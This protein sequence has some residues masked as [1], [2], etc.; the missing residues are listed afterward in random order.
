MKVKA[1]NSDTKD[2][3]MKDPNRKGWIGVDLDG[4]LARYESGQYP[5]IGEPL[6]PMADYVRA[7]IEEDQFEVKIFTA[8]ACEPEQIP[9]VKAWLKANGFPDLEVTN[10]KDYYMEQMW[11]DRCLRVSTNSGDFEC[12]PSY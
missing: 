11:D 8:R 6:Y 10:A 5:V 9:I 1:R 4:T 3:S 12:S 7:L 2:P